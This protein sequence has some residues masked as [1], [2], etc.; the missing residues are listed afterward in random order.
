MQATQGMCA[1]AEPNTASSLFRMEP[2]GYAPTGKAPRSP[3]PTRTAQN[4]PRREYS[5][6]PCTQH[7]L[8]T[9]IDTSDSRLVRS[10]FQTS[11]CFRHKYF[12]VCLRTLGF[13]PNHKANNNTLKT[14][15]NDLLISS[16][17]IRHAASG[18]RAIGQLV[19]I[20]IHDVGPF[21]HWRLGHADVLMWLFLP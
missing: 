5:E 4:S 7:P 14:L 1:P 15:T 19:A 10:K 9:E 3:T 21:C 13:F 6:L 16:S 20:D 11:H 12:T 2:P 8:S 18:G 17:E